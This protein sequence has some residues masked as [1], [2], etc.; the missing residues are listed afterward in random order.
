MEEYLTQNNKIMSTVWASDV[1][2]FSMAIFLQ[3]DI[4][5][6]MN[7]TWNKFS[8]KG[9]NAKVGRNISSNQEIYLGNEASHY[10]H[11]TVVMRKEK[12]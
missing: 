9:F 3:I 1:E 2:L 5:V 11:I 10:E 6:Y 4:F 7:D 8:F 12:S